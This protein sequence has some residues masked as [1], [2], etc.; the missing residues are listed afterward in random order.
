MTDTELTAFLEEL[1]TD[2]LNSLQS[3]GIATA[4]TAQQ[5][6]IT[7]SGQNAQL[8]VPA[9]LQI[10]ESGRGPTSKNA[11]PGNPPMIVRIQ[12]WCHERGIPETAAWAIKKKIDKLGYAGKPGL[13]TQ[14][15][16]DANIDQKLS[17]TLETMSGNI[18]SQL[19]NAIAI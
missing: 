19:L 1:K 8:Q 15:L 5:I 9:Y 12:Q 13:L 18:L 14:P 11:V 6:V 17:S 10:V 3:K 4:Q 16:G 7:A 2:L